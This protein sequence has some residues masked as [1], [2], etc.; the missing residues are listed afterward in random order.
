MFQQENLTQF[1]SLAVDSKVNL[2]DGHA[3]QT[4]TR[5]QQEIIDSFPEIFARSARVSRA[6]LRREAHREFF[7]ALGQHAYPKDPARILDC[8]ASSVAMDVLARA[9]AEDMR[10]VALVHPTFDNI[11]DLL[12]GFR[13]R[14]LPVEEHVLHE[15]DLALAVPREAGCLFITTPNNPTGR[16]LG[17][18]RLR[19]AA[20][21]CTERDMVL[22]LD[23]SFRGFDI[24]AQ[25]DHYAVLEESGCRYVV[26]EDTGKLWPTQDLKLGFLAFGAEVALP[27][28]RIH[29]EILLEVS[30]FLLA[31][32]QALAHDAAHGGLAELHEH[33][34]ANRLEVRDTLGDVPRV[35]FPDA[36]SQVSVERVHL[37]GLDCHEL[38]QRLRLHG[39]EV[40]PC[41]QFHWADHQ[42]GAS[43]L[44]LALGRDRDTVAA[45][46]ARLR[47]LL[48][49]LG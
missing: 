8:Y 28:Q 20:R 35:A 47:E 29:S 7:R 17:A 9:L 4:P 41:H 15:G 49:E 24:R 6:V 2:S 16:V 12:R 33:I 26:I 40:L 30:P 5:T 23:T 19:L 3:R 31:L 27:L 18:D 42:Q 1:E 25:Y 44:R 39:V 48:L 21:I 11:P 32:V 14:L 13:L 36:D 38:W 34:A 46:V 43:H 45:G 22:A 10:P 37:P